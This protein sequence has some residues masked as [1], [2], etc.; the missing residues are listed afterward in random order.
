MSSIEALLVN[1][2]TF[3]A[4]GAAIFTAAYAYTA[5]KVLFSG[6]E[7][8]K[9]REAQL[10]EAI[11]QGMHSGA[12]E[13]IEDFVNVYKGIHELGSDDISHRAGLAKVLREFIVKVV[14]NTSLE[15]SE[16]RRLKG[17]ATAVLK[18]IEAESPFAELPAAERNLL[19]DIDRFIKAND[20]ASAITKLQD[21]AGLVEVRQDSLSRLQSANKWSVPLAAIGLVLTVVFGIISLFK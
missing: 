18:R 2:E 14:A 16:T 21:L 1:R 11:S 12:L 13:S 20:N 15:A 3:I 10:Y 4:L 5:Q 7:Q 9:K 19:L 8:R 6:R 17:F